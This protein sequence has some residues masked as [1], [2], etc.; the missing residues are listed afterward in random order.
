[1]EID[2]AVAMPENLMDDGEPFSSE[3]YHL[4]PAAE[5][6]GEDICRQC[7]LSPYPPVMLRPDYF[8]R[9]A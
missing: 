8:A 3:G 1:M 4:R 5:A 2:A 6:L 7:R 9:I